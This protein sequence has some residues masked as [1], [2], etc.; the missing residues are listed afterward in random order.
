MRH[1]FGTSLVLWAALLAGTSAPVQAE[2]TGTPSSL[3]PEVIATVETWSRGAMMFVFFHE[4]GHMAIDLLKLPSTG[5]EEDAVDEFSTLILTEVILQAPE[6]QK[7]LFAEVVRGGA[8]FWKLLA[9]RSEAQGH[10]T[11]FYDE[12]SPDIRR[13]ANIL[14]LATGADPLRFIPMAVK[15]GIPENR[16]HRCAGD[17]KRR[18]AA[19][20]ELM[21]NYGKQG[22]GQGQDK[23]KSGGRMTL[24]IEPPR[25][26]AYKPFEEEFRR[27]NFFQKVLDLMAGAVHLPRDGPVVVMECGMANA[28]WSPRAGEIILCYEMYAEI[29]Q[30]FLAAAQGG[31]KPKGQPTTPAP[32]PQPQPRPGAG[33]PLVGTWQCQ[34]NMVGSTEQLALGADGSFRSTARD[35]MGTVS[36]WGRW[37][38]QGNLLTFQLVGYQ[39]P[40]RSLPRQIDVTYSMPDANALQI[41]VAGT[42]PG[43]CQRLQ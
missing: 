15:V 33:G 35:Y 27:D 8:L 11:P 1:R 39:P 12:H 24:K 21:E 26:A 22:Q 16:L 23:G 41:G 31:E 25:K 14:C 29:V 43:M 38:V 3:S 28:F 32:Q 10:S 6:A 17:Y 34:N 4:F 20:N 40:Q 5:P 30:V 19:W 2:Q 7:N 37:S 13:F 42:P 9:E 36:S 18:H